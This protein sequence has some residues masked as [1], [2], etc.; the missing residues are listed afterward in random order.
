MKRSDRRTST[1]RTGAGAGPKRCGRRVFAALTAVL[2]CALLLA[3]LRFAGPGTL[4]ERCSGI[5]AFVSSL[6]HA[7]FDL[8]AFLCAPPP[9]AGDA[10][11]AVNRN[12]P[13]FSREELE[14][15]R[16]IRFSELDAL[17]RCGPASACLGPE[18][19]PAEKRAPI[20]AVR[21]SGWH[22]VR[23][24]GLIEDKYLYNRC[25]LIGYQLSG[26]NADPR[27]LITGTRYL[28]VSGML[29]YENAVF[30]YIRSSGNHVLYRVTPVFLNDALLA[31]G[32]LMEARSLE[33]GGAGIRFCVYAHNV[34]PGIL[35]DYLTGESR[36][37]GGEEGPR[38]ETLF[39]LPAAEGP[40]A[41]DRSL[42]APQG[43][44]VYVLNTNTHR[45][46]DPS[47]PSVTEMSESNREYFYGSREEA[48][49]RG[50]RPCGRC[51]P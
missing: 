37:Q 20:G 27:N 34:Q 35:I 21:P 30:E 6:L 50:Y 22:T 51:K 28:N 24:D 48:L 17:G 41:A 14:S 44:P 42:P 16:S 12:R 11:T 33:D 38:P 2:V 1:A 9:Y 5:S 15:L 29:P 4:R 45:F 31:S 26:D 13:L 49:E 25:H 47:C 43:V 46:H 39:P 23:Y 40:S 3:A 32:V 18:T 7:P 36:A 10:V 19:L 8:D